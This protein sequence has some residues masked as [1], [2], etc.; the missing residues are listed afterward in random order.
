MI[1]W[2]VIERLIV[3]FILLLPYLVSIL[4]LVEI[5]DKELEER[6]SKEHQKWKEE[7]GI[8]IQH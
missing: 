8:L 6:N 2:T 5:W 7:K 3:V 1:N 4:Y